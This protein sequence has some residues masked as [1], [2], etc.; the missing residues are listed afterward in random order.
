[1]TPCSNAAWSTSAPASS[2]SAPTSPWPR[3]SAPTWRPRPKTP[4]SGHWS[5]KRRSPT[6]KRGRPAATPTR[7]RANEMRSAVRSWSSSASKMRYSTACRPSCRRR[8]HPGGQD[9]V[10]KPV[11]VIVAEDEAI[12]RL[13]LKEILE[14]EGYDVVG[15]TGRGDQAIDLVRE[16]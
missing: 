14:E 16:L 2:G 15:E 12:I 13:D 9:P 10:S 7:R 4:G 6:P 1:R 8:D 3:S 5:R 11:R